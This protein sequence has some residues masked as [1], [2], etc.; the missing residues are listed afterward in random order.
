MP[1]MQDKGIAI[2]A[3]YLC[4]RSNRFTRPRLR[5]EGVAGGMMIERAEKLHKIISDMVFDIQAGRINSA[6]I[7]MPEGLLLYVPKR[8][9][10]TENIEGSIRAIYDDVLAN[11]PGAPEPMEE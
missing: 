7:L 11:T 9:L 6:A 8:A 10:K 4:G 1:V 3:K 2:N 5:N